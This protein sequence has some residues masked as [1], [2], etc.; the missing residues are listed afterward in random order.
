VTL[1]VAAKV[2][3]ERRNPVQVDAE[4]WYREG[5]VELPSVI[6]EVPVEDSVEA[7]V[8]EFLLLVVILRQS[9]VGSLLVDSLSVDS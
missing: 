2:V 9:S 7:D 6:S 5:A 8:E 1:R 4:E 3:G